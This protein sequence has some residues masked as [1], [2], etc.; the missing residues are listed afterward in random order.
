MDEIF[1]FNFKIGHFS[2]SAFENLGELILNKILIIFHSF[3]NYFFLTNLFV[4]MSVLNIEPGEKDIQKKM[5]VSDH[6]CR[7]LTSPRDK[8]A[9]SGSGRAH[10]SSDKNREGKDIHKLF[11]HPG[12][13]ETGHHDDSRFA[14]GMTESLKSRNPNIQNLFSALPREAYVRQELGGA[15]NIPLYLGTSTQQSTIWH[16]YTSEFPVDTI[17]TGGINKQ[18]LF[19]GSVE[20]L[21]PEAKP[22]QPPPTSF[23][24]DEEVRSSSPQNRF[25]KIYV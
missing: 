14:D 7:D 25:K 8:P 21:E 13:I 17:K 22:L 4:R 18:F 10:E 11:P 15:P 12:E 6:E 5:F 3:T 20:L 24:E 19:S 16:S 9:D 2:F 1:F 23:L